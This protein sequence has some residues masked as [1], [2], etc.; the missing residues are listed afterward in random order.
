MLDVEVI[1]NPGAA[2]AALSPLR[3]RLLAGLKSPASAAELA[4]REGLSRQKVNYHLRALESHGLVSVAEERTWGGLTE[5]RLIASA[6]SYVVS[7]EA[8]GPIAADPSRTTDRLSAGYLVAVAARAVREV[9]D[10]LHRATSSGKRLAT[11][12]IDTTVRFRSASD[13]A[14]FSREL[15]TA[16]AELVA[17]YHDEDAPE[18]RPHRLAILAHPQLGDD[19]TEVSS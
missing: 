17:R 19:S 7:P 18:G 5:R 6:G 3:G 16:V 8:L 1:E 10:L 2:A 9:G 13:R 15:S 14:A 4:A 12:S 11:L